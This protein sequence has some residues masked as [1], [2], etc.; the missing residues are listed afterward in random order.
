[1]HIMVP[2]DSGVWVYILRWF[3]HPIKRKIAK[4]YLVLLRKIF[5][6]KVI[7]ITGSAG[8]TTAKEM[9]YSILQKI[10]PTVAT[11]ANIDPVYNIPTTILRCSPR[12]KYL[13]LEMGVEHPGEMDFYLWLAK[14]DVGVIT[15]IFYTHTLFL[16]DI[17]GVLREKSKLVKSLLKDDW[18]ILN[19]EDA[20][21]R[22]LGEKIKSRIIWY[23]EGGFVQ[24]KDIAFVSNTKTNFKL[25]IGR[26]EID[27]SIPVYGEHFV[28]NALAASA[29]AFVLGVNLDSIAN[30]LKNV[31]M[32]EHRMNVFVHKSGALIVDD[33][34]NNNPAAANATLKAFGELAGNRKKL[35]VM[36]DMLELGR[37]EKSEHIKLGKKI[38]DSGVD[39]LI[40][41][42]KASYDM[43]EEAKKKMGQKNVLWYETKD[44]VL[45]SLKPFLNKD[46]AI[47][48]KGSRSIG[49]DKLISSLV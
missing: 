27:A 11:V 43:V 6:V 7:G 10:A 5:G 15:N 39:F 34:Y 35:V 13:I 46:W 36:G 49:L 8:K 31:H 28:D 45:K 19:E 4:Y 47:L 20:R 9:V 21:L 40:G 16:D 24:A 26:N 3:I 41:V 18:S 37:F 33:T 1:M 30:G 32:Q 17:E 42:G 44:Q 25:T 48:I 14:P 22:K 29:A 38:S 12:T 23:G 2:K